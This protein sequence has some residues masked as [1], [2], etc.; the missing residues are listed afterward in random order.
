MT[1]QVG[2]WVRAQCVADFCKRPVDRS[3]PVEE[4]VPGV[5]SVPRL[6]CKSCGSELLT[7]EMPDA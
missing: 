7:K 3:V 5:L 1:V 2:K 4:I 6:M